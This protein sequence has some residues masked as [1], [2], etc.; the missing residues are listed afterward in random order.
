MFFSRIVSVAGVVSLTVFGLA[1]ADQ[2]ASQPAPTFSKDVAPIFFN[3]CSVCHHPGGAAPFSVL[4]YDSVRQYSTLIAD[5]TGK[6]LMPPWKAEPG[7]GEYVG[8][9]PLTTA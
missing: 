8:L 9:E 5:V 2:N 7:S 3:K 4:T 6:R 1:S